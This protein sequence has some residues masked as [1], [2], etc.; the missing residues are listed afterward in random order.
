MSRPLIAYIDI[1]ALE[2]NLSV[3]RANAPNSKV[4][5]VVKA[6][7]YGHGL[8]HCIRA[9]R[10]TDGYALI[11]LDAAIAM[12]EAGYTHPIL[13]L[14]GFFSVHELPIISHYGMD[15]VVHCEEQLAML[16]HHPATQGLKVHLKM[17]TGMN[18]LGFHPKQFRSAYQRLQSLPCVRAISLV[19][20]MA[21]AEDPLHPRMPV[22]EQIQRF[23][24][25]ANGLGGERSLSNSATILL[26]PEVRGD[27]VRPGIML[28]GAS[29]GG[30]TAKEFG[31][32][33]A[34]TLTSAIIQIQ[35]VGEGEP[36]GYGSLFVTPQAMRI[37]V[38]AC[39][40]ADGYPRNAPNGTPILV[41]GTRTSLVGCVSMDMI[42]VDLTHIPQACP[43]SPVVL[44]GG[45]LPVDEV[46]TAT[47]TIG[48]ELM[49]ALSMRPQIIA[50]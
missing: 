31:L 13:L 26:H 12:R 14:E 5:A 8:E 15:V 2:H 24:E 20:H 18:R 17:N 10:N 7:A 41:E 21:N 33:P 39:G 25:G 38:V 28:Y 23:E 19:T 43:G 45:E 44:W 16:E 50:C 42:T 29:P 4:W 40:Y 27:W 37:G 1:G 3:V 11:E 9:L 22:S 48:Y 49:C 6:N 46:A 36:V 32:K 34:M 47:G 35:E 30:K